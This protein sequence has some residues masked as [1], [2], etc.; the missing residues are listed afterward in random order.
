MEGWESESLTSN[1]NSS[2][3][4]HEL[5]KLCPNSKYKLQVQAETLGSRGPISNEIRALSGQT[6]PPAPAKVTVVGVDSSSVEV[7][8]TAI[9]VSS[10]KTVDGY[11]VRMILLYRPQAWFPVAT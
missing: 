9:Q 1:C 10:N 5:T 2:C 8:W 3:C 11:W 6:T 4:K 7:E